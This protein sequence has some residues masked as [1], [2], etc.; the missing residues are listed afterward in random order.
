[1]HGFGR[2]SAAGEES[3]LLRTL[4]QRRGQAAEFLFPH[5]ARRFHLAM[6]QL[7]LRCGKCGVRHALFAQFVENAGRP[8]PAPAHGGC[9][10]DEARLGQ[11]ATLF[12]IVE[13]GPDLV[14]IVGKRLQP[15]LQ[16]LPGMFA[17]RQGFQRAGAQAEGLRRQLGALYSGSTTWANG[18]SATWAR[19][20]V[21]IS[22]A[23]SG[24]AL[25]KSRV[26]SL[27]WPMRSLP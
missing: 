24:C 17:P 16:F 11:P 21:S 1:M 13:Q 4:F 7:G 9:V 8:E 3:R 2:K 14:R 22:L 5:R 26:L 15:G 18:F 25:R 10:L 23:I 20:L 12:Q 6:L 19:I 27:P